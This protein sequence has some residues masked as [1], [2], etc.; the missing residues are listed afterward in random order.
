[1]K[2]QG[3]WIGLWQGI[4]HVAAIYSIA[5]FG[6]PWMLDWAQ[7]ILPSVNGRPHQTILEFVFSHLFALGVIAGLI[8][9]T[10]SA[11]FLRHGIVRFVWV[12]P[13]AALVLVFVIFAPGMY[14]TMIWES[15]FKQA[16]RYFFGSDFRFY[17]DDIV[18]QAYQVLRLFRQLHFA[19]PA[20]VGAT[21]SFGAWLSLRLLERNERA[22]RL[23]KEPVIP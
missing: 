20:Y 22:A 10:S 1:M 15:D 9:G 2:P 14:P 3:L 4:V 11:R 17:E 6:F 13:V 5:W 7:T 23:R 16:F 21:Y 19:V 12:I 18:M 8:A